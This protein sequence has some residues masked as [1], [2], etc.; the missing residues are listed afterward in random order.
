M[1]VDM[2]C[3]FVKFHGKRLHCSENIPKSFRG[4]LI[5]ETPCS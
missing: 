4:L 2:N 3:Q 1:Y 5:I